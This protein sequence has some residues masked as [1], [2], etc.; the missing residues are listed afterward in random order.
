[1]RRNVYTALQLWRKSCQEHGLC[2]DA[3]NQG[4]SPSQRSVP[5]VDIHASPGNQFWLSVND[6]PIAI[7]DGCGRILYAD[8]TVD[9]V[10]E[11]NSSAGSKEST[12]PPED[13][14]AHHPK[15]DKKICCIIGKA[16]SDESSGA[17][18]VR[19][20]CDCEFP[21]VLGILRSVL[22]LDSSGGK[23]MSKAAALGLM[24]E[25]TGFRRAVQV[26][27]QR[28]AETPVDREF[29]P[30]LPANSQDESTSIEQKRTLD[31]LLD[32]DKAEERFYAMLDVI[33][34]GSTSRTAPDASVVQRFSNADANAQD[35]EHHSAS[36][37]EL[38][39]QLRELLQMY[40]A[41]CE[42]RRNLDDLEAAVVRR[43]KITEASQFVNSHKKQ[44][45]KGQHHLVQQDKYRQQRAKQNLQAFSQ[46]FP[47][48]SLIRQC[49]ILLIK[50]S[51][52][53]YSTLLERASKESQE[54]QLANNQPSLEEL[55]QISDAMLA[56]RRMARSICHGAIHA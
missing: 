10:G 25:L 43:L 53:L 33:G 17:V 9:L 31:D 19:P 4:E 8:K 3:F 45:G 24:T 27:R 41:F 23:L 12:Q 26:A 20:G 46:A 55:D 30:S 52:I 7:C 40:A 14:P 35:A 42:Q 29:S 22:R 13:L 51:S 44:V 48:R 34:L 49:T 5:T 39:E 38:S 16:I 54:F 18:D 1:M 15:G 28:M 2:R 36:L 32:V 21:T 37:S 11:Q 56:M 6:R 50:Q 47:L